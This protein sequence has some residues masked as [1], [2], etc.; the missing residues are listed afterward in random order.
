MNITT[1]QRIGEIADQK[2]INLHKLADKAGVSYNTLYSI[3]KRKS[4]KVDMATIRKIALA[5]DVHPIE[6]LG[7]SALGFIEYGMDM[8]ERGVKSALDAM[9]GGTKQMDFD[10]IQVDIK[11][12]PEEMSKRTELIKSFSQLNKAGQAKAVERVEELTEIPKYQ[13]KPPQD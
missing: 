10:G 9:S 8:M 3:V 4:D 7:D 13:K 11:Y 5:L 2:G 6:I 12:D 1:G